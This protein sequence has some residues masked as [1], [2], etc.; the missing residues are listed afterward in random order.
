[1]QSLPCT[2]G[3]EYRAIPE[4]PG[5]AAGNDGSVWS[6]RLRKFG[7]LGRT[8]HTISQHAN[9][10]GYR[11]ARV[12][13]NGRSIGFNVH[14]LVLEAFVGPRPDGLVCRH[15]DGNCENNRLDNLEWGTQAENA[16]DRIRH[17]TQCRGLTNGRSKLT[18]EQVM[19]IRREITGAGPA[20]GVGEKIRRVSTDDTTHRDESKL[21]SRSL[22]NSP[23][24][25]RWP[26]S[27][28]LEM[29]RL[30]PR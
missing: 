18:E 5:Y 3:V 6:C 17:G 26:T 24:G 15:L 1:M 14:R 4:L 12:R 30:S 19:A 10:K 25:P 29:L 28:L 21:G 22:K 13:Q 7:R 2:P 9:K 23:E 11:I 20:G 27:I 16:R 8:W